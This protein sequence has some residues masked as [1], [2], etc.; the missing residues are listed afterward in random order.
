MMEAV[1]GSLRGLGYSVMPMIVSAFGACGL[2]I[3][4]IFTVFVWEG[5]IESLFLSYPVEW[6]VTLA[7]HLIC[8]CVVRKK[9]PKEDAVKVRP[10]MVNG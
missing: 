8:F 4:W 9:F 3:L 6:A 2:R 5:S 1:V 10:V 7:V